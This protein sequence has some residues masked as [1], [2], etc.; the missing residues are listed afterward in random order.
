AGADERALQAD[1]RADANALAIQLC[2]FAAGCREQ[3]LPHRVVDDCV[4]HAP[5]TLHADRHRKVRI[6]VQEVRSA[7]ERVDDP[8]EFVV[9]AAL[10][11][12]LRKKSM[13]RIAAPY[14]LDDVPLRLRI[15]LADEV[16][17][18]LGAHLEAVQPVQAANDDLSSAARGLNGDIQ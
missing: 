10:T 1:V 14:G 3:L 6:A 2:A 17:L 15:D 13:L 5:A 7:V 12:F 18:A 11:A 8:D 16:V 9:V 4:L